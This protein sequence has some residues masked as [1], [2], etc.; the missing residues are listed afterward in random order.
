MCQSRYSRGCRRRGAFHLRAENARVSDSVGPAR[1]QVSNAVDIGGGG[2]GAAIL[3]PTV[4]IVVREKYYYPGKSAGVPS[5][6]QIG[7]VRMELPMEAQRN[8]LRPVTSVRVPRMRSHASQE[9]Q[10]S[11]PTLYKSQEKK[12]V[13]SRR[14]SVFLR[15]AKLG[16]SER[17]DWNIFPFP[18]ELRRYSRTTDGQERATTSSPNLRSFSSG[19][20]NKYRT[21]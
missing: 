1:M 11:W 8:F 12:V 15:R 20:G 16:Q 5:R 18:A 13:S 9:K 10:T 21:F 7:H 14:K 6:C 17:P 3:S 2:G 19:G 4:G